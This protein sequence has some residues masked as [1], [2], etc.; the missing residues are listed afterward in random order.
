MSSVGASGSAF[1]SFKF[2]LPGGYLK[3]SYARM[4][5]EIRAHRQAP[6]QAQQS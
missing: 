6:A 5:R 4:L 1:N 3:T 2:H